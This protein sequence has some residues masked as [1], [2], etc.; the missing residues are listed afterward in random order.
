[1]TQSRVFQPKPFQSIQIVH[2]TVASVICEDG[3]AG[4]DEGVVDV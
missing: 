1:M 3:V 4:G 2:A